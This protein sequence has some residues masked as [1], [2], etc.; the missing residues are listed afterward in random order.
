MKHI[1]RLLIA[2]VLLSACAAVPMMADGGTPPP[3]CTPKNCPIGK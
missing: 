3:T 2:M 1:V